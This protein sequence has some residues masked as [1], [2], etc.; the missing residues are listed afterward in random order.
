MSGP[1]SKDWN[2]ILK[3]ARTKDSTKIV[4]DLLTRLVGCPVAVHPHRAWDGAFMHDGSHKRVRG[5][6]RGRVTSLDSG[7]RFDSERGFWKESHLR[8]CLFTLQGSDV[9]WCVFNLLVSK[10]LKIQCIKL[11]CIKNPSIFVPPTSPCRFSDQPALCRC[12]RSRRLNQ[13]GR[14][15]GSRQHTSFNWRYLHYPPSIS[16]AGNFK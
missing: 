3:R 13:R 9:R 10:L 6:D 7:E 15:L 5:M 4:Q 2:C 11:E 14:R 12:R 8:R 16:S 1:S